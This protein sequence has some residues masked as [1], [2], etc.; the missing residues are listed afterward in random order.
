M[1]ESRSSSPDRQWF[2]KTTW[3]EADEQEFH[4]RLQRAR[5]SYNKAQYLRIQ[6]HHLQHD[7]SPP[8]F[9][10]A[11][12]LLELLVA[13]YPEPSELGAAYLQ[14][15]QCREALGRTDEAV[16]AMRRAVEFS[17]TESGARNTDAASHFA[18][19]VARL[20]LRDHY[21]AALQLFTPQD[22]TLIL[23]PV[24]ARMHAAMALMAADT[25]RA[26]AASH[27]RQALDLLASS[28]PHEVDD[29]LRAR[30]Q[31]LAAQPR[32]SRWKFWG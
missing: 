23:P 9:E 18:L 30:L 17:T 31:A 10:A 16:E 15:A 28:P 5:S 26:E 20:G 7:A 13:Q 14:L 32:K 22:V 4:A 12:A 6:A 27:A 11:Q 8:Q 21:D 3:T 1:P 19:L 2:R 25:G 24:Q 29:A